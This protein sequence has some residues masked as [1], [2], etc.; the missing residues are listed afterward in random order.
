[1]FFVAI[2]GMLLLREKL[3]KI[4]WICISVTFVGS[5]VVAM[6]DLSG[7]A[8]WGDVLALLGALWAAGYT[9]I[10]RR[11]R[12]TLST[13]AYTW[14]VYF[15]AG[16]VVLAASMATGSSVVPVSL[17][18]M[19]LALGLTVF[20]TLLGHSIFSWGLKYEKAAFVSTVKLL[21][22]VF[23]TIIGFLIFGEA[24]AMTSVVGGIMI[25]LGI[26]FLCRED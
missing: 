18:N 24:P 26:A 8:L 3:S 17:K 6:G 5:V 11:M 13:T 25:I 21:E 10:G 20:S 9:L 4:G 1:V 12:K 22:P 15:T 14:I 23:A 2:G 19:L 16:L 7:G